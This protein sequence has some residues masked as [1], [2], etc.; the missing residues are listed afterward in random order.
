MFCLQCGQT[1]H[2][3]AAADNDSLTLEETSDPMLQR[4]IRDAED[5]KTQFRPP[6]AAAGVKTADKAPAP[7][8]ELKQP[9]KSPEGAKKVRAGAKLAAPAVRG[10]KRS[11]VSLHAIVMA[12]RPLSPANML[13][14]NVGGAGAMTVGAAGGVPAERAGRGLRHLVRDHFGFL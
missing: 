7:Q 9:P 8:P 14:G 11:F 1:L 6:A 10:Q 3:P 12:P 13:A 4:A 2:A 5:Y